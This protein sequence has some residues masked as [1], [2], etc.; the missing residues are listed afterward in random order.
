MF[1]VR[2][3][4]KSTCHVTMVFKPCL[5]YFLTHTMRYDSEANRFCI[6]AHNSCMPLIVVLRSA[7]VV[8][9]GRS[10]AGVLVVDEYTLLSHVKKKC[11]IESI[12]STIVNFIRLG[13]ILDSSS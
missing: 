13:Q 2:K 6:S 9:G 12:I 3:M 7:R 5:N 1:S 4:F 11:N 8:K 10:V